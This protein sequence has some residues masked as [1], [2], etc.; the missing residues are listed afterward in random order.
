MSIRRTTLTSTSL[1]SATYST[2]RKVLDIEFQDRSVYRYFNVPVAHYEAL[3]ESPSPGN[4]F[5]AHI[6]QPFP[7]RRRNPAAQP[8]GTSKPAN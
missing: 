1:T 6:R 8:Q 7:H 3:L 4:Y 2:T 5:N